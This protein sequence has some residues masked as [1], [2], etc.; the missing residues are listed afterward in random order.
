MVP[1][2]VRDGSGTR[3]G[4]KSWTADFIFLSFANDGE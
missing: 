2:A 1:A 4:K 3:K